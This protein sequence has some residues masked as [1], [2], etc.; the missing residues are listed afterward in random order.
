MHETCC[1]AFAASPCPQNFRRTFAE[2][3]ARQ[4]Y[5]GSGG[6]MPASLMPDV[7]SDVRR[8]RRRGVEEQ[9]AFAPLRLAVD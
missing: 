7:S 1:S 4:Q 8:T 6:F 3:A 5:G 9:F 2:T